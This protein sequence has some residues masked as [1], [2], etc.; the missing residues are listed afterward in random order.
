ML[1]ALMISGMAISCLVGTRSLETRSVPARAPVVARP[2]IAAN[3]DAGASR[4]E[5]VIA[6]EDAPGESR[7]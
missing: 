5:R 6:D 1:G 3:I 4:I 7:A 2:G